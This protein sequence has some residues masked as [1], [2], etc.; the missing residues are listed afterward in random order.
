MKRILLAGG[1][2]FIGSNLVVR[3]LEDGHDVVVVDSLLTGSR[4][5]LADVAD[6]PRL[7]I[8]ERDATTAG[9]LAGPFDIVFHL[10]SPAS[11]P[12]YMRYPLET[13]HAGSIVTERLLEVAHRDGAR[14]VITSTSEVYGDP[15]EHPQRESY[16]GNVNPI[17][18]R[19]AYDEA[20]RYAEALTM[21][22][23][24][25]FGADTGIV[26]LFNTYGPR[27]T[28]DDGRAIPAFATAALRGAPFRIH[29]SGTQTRS[30]CFVDDAVDALV[31]MAFSDHPG[32]INIGSIEEQTLLGIAELIAMLAGCE[33]EF[34]FE[35][36]PVDDP[37]RRRP[38][39]TLAREVLGWYPKVPIRDGLARTLDWYRT[40]LDLTMR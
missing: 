40:R 39:I 32:P 30:L 25:T 23:R 24:S 15:H 18:P 35:P 22:Y 6:H 8:H 31:R 37:E 38:D 14:F 2:G 21:A 3:L 11:P 27:M 20:K 34:A 10:A 28:P 16:W 36:R 12:H 4:D 13:L 7:T 26:R 29:G 17:G 19:S 9:E 1:A 33:A 5:N